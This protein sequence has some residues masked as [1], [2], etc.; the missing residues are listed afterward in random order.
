MWTGSWWHVV[1]VRYYSIHYIPFIPLLCQ[2]QLPSGQ[3]IVPVIIATNKTQLTQFSSGKSAYP[4][5]I[6][7]GNIPKSISQKPSYHACILIGYLSVDKISS[8]NRSS[9]LLIG[10]FFMNQYMSF[11][12]LWKRQGKMVLSWWGEMDLFRGYIPYWHYM[13]LTIQNSA[14]WHVRN[15]ALVLNVSVELQSFKML[16]HSLLGLSLGWQK[17]LTMQ[18]GQLYTL[19]LILQLPQMFFIK[20]IKVYSNI[21]QIGANTS[22]AL[23]SS[24]TT[25][26]VSHLLLAYIISKMASPLFL[27]CLAQRGKTQQRSS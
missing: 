17:S 8:L 5:Y 25:F 14:W 9:V 22:W 21:W 24:T 26:V 11:W 15:M 12:L 3:T 18:N 23:T 1:Q 13:L 4:V 27:N 19:I 10:V 7:L 20:Y 6:T 2:S 16:I